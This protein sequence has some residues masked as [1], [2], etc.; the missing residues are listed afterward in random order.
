MQAA[1][2]KVYSRLA[3]WD[4]HSRY[5]RVPLVTDGVQ[6]I[7]PLELG[8]G[9]DAARYTVVDID[10]GGDDDD[11]DEPGVDEWATDWLFWKTRVFRCLVSQAYVDRQL[12]ACRRVTLKIH[13]AQVKRREKIIEVLRMQ[14]G[15]EL[16]TMDVLMP[17]AQAIRQMDKK[18]RAMEK[19]KITALKAQFNFC[20]DSIH[21]INRELQA[22]LFNQ[23]CET[24]T[25]AALK[26]LINSPVDQLSKQYAAMDVWGG[27]EDERLAEIQTQI[28]KQVERNMTAPSSTLAPADA[29]FLKMRGEAAGKA[30][31][32]T[33]DAFESYMIELE[34]REDGEEEGSIHA[35]GTSAVATQDAATPSATKTKPHGT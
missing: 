17:E 1:A 29:A 9:R 24:M 34:E 28:A 35:W 30:Y 3:F 4:D 14:L 12:K 8:V 18:R 21:N 6:P 2:K 22:Q 16:R 25:I 32:G 19:H 23:N 13:E 33:G 7:S 5:T 27:G 31:H 15:K 26:D 10:G 20:H 11:D